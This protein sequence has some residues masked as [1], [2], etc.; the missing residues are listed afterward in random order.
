MDLCGG[1]ARLPEIGMAAQ[2]LHIWSLFLYSAT[3][4]RKKVYGVGSR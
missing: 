4:V 1:A 3:F 2:T